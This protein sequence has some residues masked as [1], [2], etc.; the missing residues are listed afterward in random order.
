MQWFVVVLDAAIHTMLNCT[1][2]IKCIHLTQRC[3]AKKASLVMQSLCVLFLYNLY[4]KVI[5]VLQV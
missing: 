1:L 2:F 5:W 3:L 4:V